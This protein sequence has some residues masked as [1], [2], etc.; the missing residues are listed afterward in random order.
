MRVGVISGSGTEQLPELTGVSRATVGTDHGTVEVTR[1]SL[2]GVDV[3][4]IPR[5]GPGHA[6]LSSQVDHRRNLA[7]LMKAGADCLISL[8]VCGAVDP[9]VALGSLVVFDDSYFL[10]NRPPDGTLCT[11]HTVAGEAGRGLA[12]TLPG[13]GA[14]APAGVV[15]RFDP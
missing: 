1:G 8:T 12:L 14:V 4:H 15:H 9:T 7:A 3:V 5:H 6:R 13:V 11:W 10:G 2:A